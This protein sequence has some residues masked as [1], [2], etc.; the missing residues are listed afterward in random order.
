MIRLTVRGPMAPLDPG[1]ELT[2]YRIVQEALTNARRHAPGAPVDVELDYGPETLRVLVRDAG[3][4]PAGADGG[5]G[6]L[7][8]SERVA[9]VG[10]RLT[11]EPGGSGGFVVDA[12]LP[13]VAIGRA[14]AWPETS[15][16]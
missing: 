1:V 11:A 15:H 2:A 10:G 16:G 3:P 9:A 7:G 13:R 6:L 5:L 12:T 4:G 8:M 14:P